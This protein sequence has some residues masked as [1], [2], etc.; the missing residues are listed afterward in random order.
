[1]ATQNCTEYD[2][3]IGLLDLL[4]PIVEHLRLLVLAPLLVG[5]VAYGGSYLLS[6]TYESVAVQSGDAQLA[7][8]YNS[9]QVR[10]KVVELADY[11]AA[12]ETMP[13]A[14]DRLAKNLVVSFSNKNNTVSI[15]AKGASPAQAQKIAQEAIKV[16]AQLN[17]RR[18]DDVSRLRE[19]F[20]LAAQRERE[21]ATAAEKI[22]QKISQGSEDVAA[23]TQAQAQLLGAAREAQM[24]TASLA[25]Q[26]SQAQNF[27]LLQ[28]PTLPYKRSSPNRAVIAVITALGCG[29]FLLLFVFGQ[30]A[31]R[32]ARQNADSAKKLADIQAALRK[33]LGR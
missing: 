3:E 20:N 26:L 13:Q 4:L 32:A 16:A 2:D 23:L 8:M 1:M 17:Q 9:A 15:V 6:P 30:Y 28:Q 31:I 12:D 25:G 10:A 33:V 19:Q 5:V 7:A 24:T 14:A 11:K 27:D 29:F 21:Y 18:V 22:A